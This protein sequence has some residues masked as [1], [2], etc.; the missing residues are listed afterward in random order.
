[1]HTDIVFVVR[2]QKDQQNM[3]VAEHELKSGALKD[4][5]QLAKQ[6][7]EKSLF[8]RNRAKGPNPLAVR[9]KQKS[10][11]GGGAAAAKK[12]PEDAARKPKRKR[13]RKRGAVEKVISEDAAADAKQ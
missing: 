5:P 9:K 4:L 6:P 13:V 10:G 3:G 2:A 12:L 8:R 7:R 11:N 1:M